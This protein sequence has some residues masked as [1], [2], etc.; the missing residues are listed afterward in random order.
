[1][2]KINKIIFTVLFIIALAVFSFSYIRYNF[3]QENKTQKVI[4]KNMNIT[5][6]KTITI[7]AFGDSLTAGYGLPLY[8]SY[9]SQLEKILIKNELSV[10]VINAGVSGETTK[11][12][13][14][15]ANFIREQNPDIV[16]LGIGG[17]DALRALPI[18]EAERNIE[19]T[20]KIL[21]SGE[22]PPKLLLLRM[23]APLNSG[24]EYKKK[25][26]GIF[27]RLST[28]YSLPLIPFIVPEVALNKRYLQNDGVHPTKEGYGI[29]VETYIAP[30]VLK[31]I[32]NLER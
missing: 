11:G 18:E 15:R 30:I 23:Q 22:R 5:N 13:L 25:F 26:D 32:T 24:A 7:I 10:T 27:P 20:V 4:E 14:E 9:P 12:N 19:N 6:T 16:I 21:L 28:T 8:E 29:L 17:N 3:T 2:K 31:I 1:M